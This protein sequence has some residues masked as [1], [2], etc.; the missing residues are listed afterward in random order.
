MSDKRIIPD[1]QGGFHLPNGDR[2][3]PDG[4]GGFHI[5]GG[6]DAGLSGLEILLATIIVGVQIVVGLIYGFFWGV[7]FLFS[8]FPWLAYT[9]TGLATLFA[10]N[11]A[12]KKWRPGHINGIVL[13]IL[14]STIATVPFLWTFIGI[15]G[16]V[17]SDLAALWPVWT[18]SIITFVLVYLLWPKS[19]K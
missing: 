7:F 4:M 13:G 1:K 10:L 2:A 15:H 6:A 18:S 16:A 11:V 9:I 5:L 14:I 3:V 8:H 12:R 17:I 19:K